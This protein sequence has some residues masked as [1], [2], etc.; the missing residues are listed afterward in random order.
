MLGAIL[1][2]AMGLLP[3]TP[4]LVD[5]AVTVN[6]T[7]QSHNQKAVENDRGIFLAYIRNRNEAYTA[8]QWRLVHSTDGGDSFETIYESTDATNPPVIESDAESN[9]YLAHP[10]FG[11][12]DAY[13]YVFRASRDFRDP[14][15]Y[16]IP[17]GSA[18]KYCMLLDAARGQIYYASHNGYLATLGLDGALRSSV[19]C[20]VAGP[21]AVQQYPHL[22]LGEDGALYLAWTTNDNERYLYRAI[23]C[24]RSNDGGRSWERLNAAPLMLPVVADDSG[25]TD[26]VSLD[27][28]FEVHTWLSSMS[29]QGGKLHFAYLAQF[30]ATPRQHYMRFGLGGEREID[31]TPEFRGESLWVASLDGFFTEEQDTLFYTSQYGGHLV[32]LRSADKGATWQDHA[33]SEVAFSPYAIGGARQTSRGHVLGTFTNT[34]ANVTPQLY[35]LRVSTKGTREET[36]ATR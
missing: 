15:R 1:F 14:E 12:S 28:E 23:H 33:R 29:T 13:L 27:D 24:M 17:N 11:S 4:V 22:A 36:M 18:G 35:L 21:T 16:T 8:Q 7:F 9:L 30:P 25:P 34:P 19:Q 26:R 32:T 5:D 31:L 2:C 3:I 20:H 10:D 6:A